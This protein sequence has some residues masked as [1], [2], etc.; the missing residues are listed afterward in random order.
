MLVI[1]R[2]QPNLYVLM[3]KK[4]YEF[5]RLKAKEVREAVPTPGASQ[6]APLIFIYYIHHHCQLST[7][8]RFQEPLPKSIYFFTKKT[9][10]FRDILHNPSYIQLINP[11]PFIPNPLS[12]LSRYRHPWTA[13]TAIRPILPSRRQFTRN[14]TFKKYSFLDLKKY[15]P[16]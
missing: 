1:Y 7:K 5:A 3:N 16:L 15:S 14:Q 6:C 2:Y 12:L 11:F 4:E 13:I 10:A 9:S 8:R